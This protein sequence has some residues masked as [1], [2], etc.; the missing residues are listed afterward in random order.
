MS[1]V[2]RA[3]RENCFD[4]AADNGRGVPVV[5]IGATRTHSVF[6]EGD[7]CAPAYGR[8]VKVR[9]KR[10]TSWDGRSSGE[11]ANCWRKML[12]A[13]GLARR[14]LHCEHGEMP[15]DAR[16]GTSPRQPRATYRMR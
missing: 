12:G 10:K 11:P 1:L 6:G 14:R 8:A 15:P 2:E 3:A 7:P 16:R 5:A 9:E 13:I 4:A